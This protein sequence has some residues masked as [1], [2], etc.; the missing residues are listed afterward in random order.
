MASNF[1]IIHHR[2]NDC[3]HLKLTG[4]M[5]G[6]SAYE[7]INLLDDTSG[8][9]KEVVIETSSLGTIFPFGR[10]VFSKNFH[11]IRNRY[12]DILFTGDK[13]NLINPER[14]FSL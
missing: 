2:D 7:I 14:N 9:I 10:N 3:L 5:D 12:A 8:V 13:S 6:N 1:R 11:K 4:D